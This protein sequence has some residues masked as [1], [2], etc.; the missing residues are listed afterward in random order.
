[1]DR[2]LPTLMRTPVIGTA[3]AQQSILAL[4]NHACWNGDITLQDATASLRKL[5]DKAESKNA[6]KHCSYAKRCGTGL[7]SSLPNLEMPRLKQ[8]CFL[9]VYGPMKCGKVKVDES[10]RRDCHA[11]ER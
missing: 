9:L 3:S 10:L 6:V 8:M 5:S 11:R 1:M 4:V 2:P 7:C